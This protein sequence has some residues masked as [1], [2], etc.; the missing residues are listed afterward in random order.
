MV[1]G[2][3]TLAETALAGVYVLSCVLVGLA[4]QTLP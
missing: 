1:L 4:Q 3:I 2:T